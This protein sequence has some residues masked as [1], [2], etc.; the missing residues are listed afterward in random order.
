[1]FFITC[2]PEEQIQSRLSRYKPCIKMCAGIT[3]RDNFY[4]H[5]EK[6]IELYLEKKIDFSVLSFSLE[7]FT[8]E[9]GGLFLYAFFIAKELKDSANSGEVN[10]LSQLSDFTGD[11]DE[12]FLQN[13]QRVFDNVGGDL[14]KKLLGCI[15]AS[16]SPLLISF[17]SFVLRRE[18]S[19]LEEH[20]V[21]GGVSRF[22]VLRTG[23]RTVT[24]LHSL[25]PVWFSIRQNKS[26]EV[27]C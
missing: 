16:P 5:H 9:C 17:I 7:D 14:Y 6:D 13:F 11:I 25:I 20:D 22:V 18:N 21:T 8:T 4:Q 2:R 19:S 26:S 15:M 24:F 1:M 27:V 10:Q 23:D 3:D 12:L